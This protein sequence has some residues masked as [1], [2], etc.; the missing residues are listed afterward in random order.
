MVKNITMESKKYL[1]DGNSYSESELIEMANTTAHYDRLDSANDT[2]EEVEEFQTISEAINYLSQF[3]VVEIEKTKSKGPKNYKYEDGGKIEEASTVRKFFVGLDLSVLPENAAEYIKKEIIN[4]A[5]IDML[6]NDDSDFVDVKNYIE[7]SYPSAIMGYE[8]PN[9][10]GEDMGGDESE[11]VK[12]L[13]QEI[14]D[15]RDLI[16][17]EDSNDT[18]L[19]KKLNQEIMDLESLIELE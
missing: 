19:A 6:A 18:E 14:I 5:D 4:D 3:D 15:L 16:D 8:K 1:Y 10:M 12:K 2:E 9:E 7:S 11:L 17:L 13:K